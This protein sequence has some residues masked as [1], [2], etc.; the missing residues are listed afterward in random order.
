M[1]E[2]STGNNNTKLSGLG[3]NRLKLSRPWNTAKI[4]VEHSVVPSSSGIINVSNVSLKESS[5]GSTAGPI[6]RTLQQIGKFFN[7]GNIT[8]G[9][10]SE[11]TGVISLAPSLT[12]ARTTSISG[13][14]LAPINESFT[15]LKN[16]FLSP[17]MNE[18]FSRRDS[19]G[20]TYSF[21]RCASFSNSNSFTSPSFGS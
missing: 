10:I 11:T 2:T 19:F 7:S 15:T 16:E 18:S 14:T 1:E 20:R 12:R 17:P 5:S 6:T 13:D 8:S 9:H 21:T 4:S 3:L